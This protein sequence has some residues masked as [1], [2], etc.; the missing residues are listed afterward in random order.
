MEIMINHIKP[1]ASKLPGFW[2]I[3]ECPRLDFWYPK[4]HNITPSIKMLNNLLTFQSCDILREMFESSAIA[5]PVSVNGLQDEVYGKGSVRASG[6]SEHIADQLSQVIIRHLGILQCDEHTATDWWQPTGTGELVTSWEPVAVSPLLRFM[7]YEQDSEHYAHYDAGF[8]YPDGIHRT[9]KSLV[10]Y[11]TTNEIGATRFIR[12]GQ[13]DDKV[14][15]RN[16]DDW[17]RPVREDEVLNASYP[18][19]GKALIF[20][21][22][23]CHDV[24]QFQPSTEGEV[25]IIIRGDIIYRPITQ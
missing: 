1:C 10:I 9:L 17:N 7:K 16:H 23:L 14:W 18:K 2:D 15:E 5:A 22:R 8:F 21:H 6:W 19:K 13:E 24:Q 3:K 4:I 25:R 20:D 11:L 12:D